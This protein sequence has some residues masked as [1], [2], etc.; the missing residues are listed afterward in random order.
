MDNDLKKKDLLQATKELDDFICDKKFKDLVAK[1]I[2]NNQSS[3]TPHP[4]GDQKN[5]SS[6]NLWFKEFKDK[7]YKWNDKNKDFL[8]TCSDDKIREVL[9]DTCNK[10]YHEAGIEV[11]IE[12]C[13][14]FNLDP[15]STNEFQEVKALL[16][17]VQ[18][19]LSE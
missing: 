2:Q 18:E 10:L 14:K 8:K 3:Q 19:T 16:K 5:Q 9:E 15:I 13:N 4:V 1:S 12:D 7:R 6:E 17:K 11:R